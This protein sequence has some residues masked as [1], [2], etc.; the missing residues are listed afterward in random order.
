M[1]QTSRWIDRLIVFASGVWLFHPTPLVLSLEYL[2]ARRIESRYG[3]SLIDRN[4][5]KRAKKK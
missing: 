3:Q 1:L 2:V 5:G 4:R